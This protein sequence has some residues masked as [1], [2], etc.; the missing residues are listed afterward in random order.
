VSQELYTCVAPIFLSCIVIQVSQSLERD[1]SQSDELWNIPHTSILVQYNLVQDASGVT[2][3]SLKQRTG[4]QHG[5]TRA[6]VAF[7]VLLLLY[8]CR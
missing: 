1:I 7:I 6:S 2:E 3:M 5:T 4:I 8:I